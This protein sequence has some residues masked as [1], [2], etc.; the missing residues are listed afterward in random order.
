[1]ERLAREGAD[2][3]VEPSRRGAINVRLDKLR[4]PAIFEEGGRIYSLYAVAGK[5]GI[6]L[7]EV[8]LEP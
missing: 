4:D 7:T 1:M 3:P 5:R 2:L 8:H 6:A